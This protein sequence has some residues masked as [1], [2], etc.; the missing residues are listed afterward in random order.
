VVYYGTSIAQ[1][2]CASRPGMAF[3]NILERAMDRSY[4]NFGFS[5]N[6]TF[7]KSVGEAM[8]EIDA[9]LYVIDC[10]PNTQTE[11]IYDRAIVLVKQLKLKRPS[12]PILFV[13][14]YNYESGFGNPGKLNTDKKLTEL[15][16]AFKLLQEF[17]VSDIFYLKGDRLIGYDHE[18]TVDGVHPNDLGMMRMAES[19]LPVIRKILNE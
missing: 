17:G 6:G 15:H 8:C 12:V 14:A 11:L 4:I 3:T 16:R 19:L 5:S 13:D 7:D 2:G 10:I 9:S 18:G 1:G